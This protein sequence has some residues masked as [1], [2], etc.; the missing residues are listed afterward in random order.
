MPAAYT[1]AGALAQM[2]MSIRYKSTGI[3]SFIEIQ[4]KMMTGNILS[5]SAQLVEF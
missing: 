2:A 3:W 1:T 5:E 4:G